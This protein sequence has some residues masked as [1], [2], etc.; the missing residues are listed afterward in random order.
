MER[1]RQI[2]G[3]RDRHG[4]V[5]RCTALQAVG[6]FRRHFP[7]ARTINKAKGQPRVAFGVARAVCLPFCPI[8]GCSI[9]LTHIYFLI[10]GA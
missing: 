8:W 1:E 6:K 3:E 5:E 4:Q 10:L 2:E 7:W 9:E